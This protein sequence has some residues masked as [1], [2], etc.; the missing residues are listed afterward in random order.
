MSDDILSP[1]AKD[2]EEEFE[3][4]LRPKCLSDFIGQKK[5]KETLSVFID[6]TKRRGE[7]L[8]HLLFCGPPGLGKTTLAG[9]VANELGVRMKST[10]GPAIERTGDIAAI[11]TN[12]DFGEVLFV[13]EIHR[14]PRQV[15]EIFYPAMEDFQVD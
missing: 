8:D 11:L 9:I 2:E 6:A 10:S 12:I 14:L 1:R 15:E 13:D 7:A 4:A 5:I 3:K